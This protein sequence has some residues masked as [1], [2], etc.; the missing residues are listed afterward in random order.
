MW[1][2][3]NNRF[4]HIRTWDPP[5]SYLNTTCS[6]FFF[7]GIALDGVQ[8]YSTR[9]D[10]T[11]KQALQD[12]ITEKVLTIV[13]S[14]SKFLS[15]TWFNNPMCF[16]TNEYVIPKHI[17]DGR[18]VSKSL[19]SIWKFP[20][21][22]FWLIPPPLPSWNFQSLLGA[23]VRVDLELHN[24]PSKLA[25]KIYSGSVWVTETEAS[26][27]VISRCPLQVNSHPVNYSR[28]TIKTTGF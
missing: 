15:Y 21:I 10:P 24:P 6:I 14:T 22:C 13:L 25:L 1:F 17:P 4:Q 8:V 5:L 20:F 18:I 26:V 2:D 27:D 12:F 3:Q 19:L 28:Q 9:A 11:I 16:I 7:T 23:G